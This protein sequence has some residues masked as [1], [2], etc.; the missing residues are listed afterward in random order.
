LSNT[1]RTIHGVRL[2]QFESAPNEKAEAVAA[3]VERCPDCPYLLV[4]LAI[5]LQLQGERANV[6]LADVERLLQRAFELDPSH[7]DALDELA[8]FYHATFPNEEQ[9]KAFARQ[10]VQRT[11]RAHAYMR[12]ILSA[13]YDRTMKAAFDQALP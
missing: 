5:L 3:A 9:A 13:E 2:G 12:D 6:E 10:Y 11:A 7:L 1:E 4:K 8:N